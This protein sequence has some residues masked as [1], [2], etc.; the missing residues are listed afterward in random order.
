MLCYSVLFDESQERL[1]EL[2]RILRG[3]PLELII[4]SETLLS[5]SLSEVVDPLVE[6]RLDVV[7]VKVVGDVEALVKEEFERLLITADELQASMVVLPV[8]ACNMKTVT[9]SLSSIFRLAPLYSKHVLLEPSREV[10]ARVVEAINAYLG[11]VFKLSIAASPDSTTDEILALALTHLGRVSMV[12]LSNF[13]EDGR[14]T[15][16]TSTRGSINVFT[17]IKELL[18]SGYDSYFSI[19]Y[20]S[21]KAAPPLKVARRE[22]ELLNQ[23]IRSISEKLRY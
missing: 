9:A 2:G 16:V 14:V 17:V 1:T 7:A 23:Y 21:Y 3:I 5:L 4:P 13:L 20:E 6:E 10:I 15:S 19:D 11:G 18:E 22:C 8:N 12:K